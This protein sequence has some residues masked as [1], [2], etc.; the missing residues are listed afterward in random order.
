M[1][2]DQ[3]EEEIPE[4]EVKEEEDCDL[5]DYLE[6]E[7]SELVSLGLKEEI[8]DPTYEPLSYDEDPETSLSQALE[9][10]FIE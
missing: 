6:Q 5:D 8:Y 2:E 3:E 9:K 7:S 10:S 1:E 4:T